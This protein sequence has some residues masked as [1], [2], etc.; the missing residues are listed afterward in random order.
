MAHALEL[1]FDPDS[2]AKVKSVWDRLEA[3]GLPSLATRS[4][5]QHR[6]HVTLAVAERIEAT[7]IQDGQDRLAATHLDVTLHSP[8]VF[9][10]S[11]VLYLSVV[12]TLELLG[13]HQQVHAALHDSLVGS[14]GVYSV[15]A[16][17]PHCTLAQGLTREQLARGIDLLHDQ[18]SVQAHVTGAGILDTKTGEVLPVAT[19]RAHPA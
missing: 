12:P 4:H 15:G 7:R 9:Q 5:Q 10:R 6:P 17:V 8:A 13:L 18:P 14:W 11:G 16:W 3:A 1:L 19:L 2:E